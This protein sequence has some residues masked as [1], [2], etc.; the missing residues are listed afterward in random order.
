[1]KNIAYTSNP[2]KWS[3]YF[4]QEEAVNL[5]KQFII[6]GLDDEKGLPRSIY[7]SG[8]SGVGK[9]AYIR[10]LLRSLR[11]LNRKPDEYEPCGVCENCVR[12]QEER[13]GGRAYG[14]TIWLQ[15]GGRERGTL[16]AQV[17][18]A[19]IEASKGH[20]NT[21]RPDRDFLALVFDELQAF[22]SSL[23]QEV[24]LRSEIEVPNNN[25]CFIFSTMR[26]DKINVQDRIS[27]MRRS[28]PI[29]FRPFS[30][31]EICDYLRVK[32]PSAPEETIY[33]VADSSE[34]SLGL[35]LAYLERIRQEDK[36]MLPDVAAHI[37]ELAT[38]T[39]RQYLWTCLEQNTDFLS[40]VKLCN[41]L[42]LQVSPLR[43]TNQ[44]IGDI[45]RSIKQAPTAEQLLAIEC[46]NQFQQN[47]GQLNLLSHL[48]P[49]CGLTVVDKQKV[50]SKYPTLNYV[51]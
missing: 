38:P 3:D 13:L 50:L 44:L 41:E 36:D 11:C 47:Y 6:N 39:Q 1:M 12:T 25:V 2:M 10:L 43:L 24:L 4:G 5:A 17:K 29:R 32:F 40:L 22:P 37:L 23:R 7:I 20:T 51:V 8:P 26:E 15:P 35:G 9:T 31:E 18:D 34:N 45:L 48:V 42:L 28:C 27:L 30:V 33:I 46:L 14:D 19:L 49:L 16:N 21:G